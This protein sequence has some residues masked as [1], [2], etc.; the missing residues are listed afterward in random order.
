MPWAYILY[1]IY[2]QINIIIIESAVSEEIDEILQQEQN[3]WEILVGSNEK[4]Q[5]QH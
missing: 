1:T 2:Y 5:L 3:M 4:Q